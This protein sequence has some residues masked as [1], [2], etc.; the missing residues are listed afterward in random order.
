MLKPTSW[1]FAAAVAVAAASASFAQAP[2][3]AA[4]PQTTGPG[5]GGMGGPNAPSSDSPFQAPTP[6]HRM[7]QVPPNT[8]PLSRNRNDCNKVN[9][10]ENGGG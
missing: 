3:A 7:G 8:P 4:P 6:A 2:G 1:T 9:C 10:V 5:G